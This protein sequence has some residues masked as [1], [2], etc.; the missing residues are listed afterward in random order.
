MSFFGVIKEFFVSV[1]QNIQCA[2]VYGDVAGF[3]TGTVVD[4][5][6]V[7]ATAATVVNSPAPQTV[8]PG[9]AAVTFSGLNP[10]TYTV[11]AQAIAADGT[12]IG[13]AASVVVTVTSAVV[14]VSLSIPA[15]IAVTQP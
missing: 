10:D 12:P 4:H 2:I 8:P 13:P 5:V 11:S 1:T 14:T 3:P 9:T 6:I 15:S 7:S